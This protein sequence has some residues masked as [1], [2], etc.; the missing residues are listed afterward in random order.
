MN[1][2]SESPFE[3]LI[4]D[5]ESRKLHGQELLEQ[6]QAIIRE[7]NI[8]IRA[9]KRAED[10]VAKKLDLP[11]SQGSTAN[12]HGRLP[13]VVIEEKQ[14]SKV[15]EKWRDI[16][17]HLYS[18]ADAPYTYDVILLAMEERG[19]SVSKTVL[20]SQIQGAAKSGIFSKPE[21]GKYE[22]TENAIAAFDL[23]KNPGVFVSHRLQAK[24]EE[25]RRR[26]QLDILLSDDDERVK[27]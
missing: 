12:H 25:L 22:F 4:K 11:T 27:C 21:A 5:A 2:K 19:H 13:K 7:A 20:R 8:E 17:Q 14:F 9:Y 18:S 3:D 15:S 16:Y 26:S 1:K 24:A 6:A 10:A 23:K